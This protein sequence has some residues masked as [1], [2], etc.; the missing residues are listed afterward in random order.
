MKVLASITTYNPDLVRLKENINAIKGQVAALLI[1]DNGSINIQNIKFLL[2]DE[3]N[4]YF[5][6]NKNN[7]GV[8]TALKQAMDYAIKSKFDWVLTLD[9][10][11]VCAGKLVEKYLKFTYVPQVAIMTCN[12]IDRNMKSNHFDDDNSYDEI[13]SCITSGSFMNVEIYKT[14]PGF[15]EKMF[16]DGVDFDICAQ[17]NECGK[18]IIRIHYDGLLHEIG[19]GKNV[20]LLWKMYET[21]NHAPIRQYYMARNQFYLSQKYPNQFPIFRV[22]LSE[23]RIC[24]VILIY[25]KNRRKKIISRFKGVLDSRKL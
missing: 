5:Y 24:L 1:V 7:M 15:D 14:L 18:K 11:S 20:R 16:I 2:K 4:I 10:D 21:Y 25:E 22:L 17:V 13:K 6:C 3:P 19:H 12:I 8:A 23:I 9:Q